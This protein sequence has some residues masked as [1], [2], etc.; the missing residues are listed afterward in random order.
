METLP[1]TK[2]REELEVAKMKMLG[3]T[4]MVKVKNKYMRGMM[5]V[6]KFSP[7]ARE[8]RFRWSEHVKRRD[9][10]H[11]GK[12]MLEMEL[13]GKGKRGRPKRR[14]MNEVKVDIQTVDVNEASAHE[15]ED[16]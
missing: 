13:T 10:E 15:K 4:K 3:V 9:E 6:R 2:R 7:K 11:A 5:H 12:R 14:L 16:P 8:A 1:L